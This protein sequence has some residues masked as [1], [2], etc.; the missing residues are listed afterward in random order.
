MVRN[1]RRSDILGC[2]DRIRN[3]NICY[4]DKCRDE[5]TELFELGDKEF[6]F[7]CARQT[8]QNS[9][10]VNGTCECCGEETDTLFE[11]IDGSLYCEYCVED[12]LY[13]NLEKVAV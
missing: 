13:S 9:N 4:C 8:I 5:V 1:E 6:C 12:N 10:M 2:G 7:N 11:Y 3:I